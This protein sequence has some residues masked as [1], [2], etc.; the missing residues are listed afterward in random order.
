MRNKQIVIVNLRQ[1]EAETVVKLIGLES[2]WN[3]ETTT[4]P[5]AVI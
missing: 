4:G 5:Q 2:A 3:R 1:A